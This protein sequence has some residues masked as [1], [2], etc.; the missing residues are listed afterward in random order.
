M[1]ASVK[2]RLRPGVRLVSIVLS[3]FRQAW[4]GLLRQPAFLMLAV[5]TLAL[6][7]A[8]SVTV[9]G[10]V[11]RVLLRPLPY[12]QPGQLFAM[13]LVQ[14]GGWATITPEEYQA[15]GQL[16]G[17]RD[18]GIA[19]MG[20]VPMN[21]AEASDPEMAQAIAVDVGFLETLA[22]AMALGRYF[23]AEEDVP[24]GRAAVII[25][26][27]LWL[28]RFNG[29]R[30]AV[31]RSLMLEGVPMPIVGVLP[32]SFRYT[33][34]VDLLVPLA[35]PA[36]TRDNGRNY[37]AVVRL[38]EQASAPV[39]SA[40]VDA[41]MK[42]LYA[43]TDSARF[44]QQSVFGLRALSTALSAQS[45]PVLLLF[46]A[47]ALCVLLLTAVNLANLMLMRA[48]ARSHV[49]AVRGALGAS[50]TR[51]ALPMLAEG[52]LVGLLGAMAGLGLSVLALRV[53]GERIPASWFG[54][55]AD[56]AVGAT[57]ILFAL[58][59]GVLAALSAAALG[60]WRGRTRDARRELA[61]GG[62]T[63]LSRGSGRLTRGLVVAQV[64]LATVLLVGAGVFTRALVDS[65]QVDLGY[66]TDQ[67]VGFEIAPVRALYPDAPAVR[68]MGRRVVERLQQLPGAQSA[69]LAT[70]LPIGMPLNYP[71][72]VPG[73]D[74][75]SVEFR[76][77]DDGFFASF[78]IPVVAGRGF[79]G[80]DREGGEPVLA[81]NQAFAREFLGWTGDT[82]A[83]AVLDRSVQMPVGNAL[84]T[85]RVIGVVGDTRQHGPEHA[86]PPMVYL[87]FA[88]LPDMLVQMLREFMP[89]R[90]AVQL[91]GDTYAQL[92]A[93][94]AAVGEVAPGQPLA[95]L[96]PVAELV[97]ASTDGTR[98]ALLLIGTFAGLSL[99]LSAVGLYAVVAV[100][101]GTRRREFGV[102]SALGSSRSGLFRLVLGD[103]LRQVVLGLLVGLL[104]SVAATRWLGSLLS[105]LGASDPVVWLAVSA[106]LA[107]ATM[108]ACLI[109]ALRAARVAPSAALRS[110]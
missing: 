33:A 5:T 24:N 58:L 44:Y 97:R 61:G 22:P 60:V 51:L 90:F 83:D 62:R 66:R 15:I 110:E 45:R 102:R 6:G 78:G 9:V 88:Q 104:L 69:T 38:S 4:R 98:L 80:R 35:L 91:S 50:T 67:R 79:D 92:P 34:P 42:A 13:G 94:R 74:M 18:S 109:P 99:A 89:L 40:T 107:C 10:L 75:V 86:P 103:G 70:N 93:I 52:A 27:A 101:V 1:L 49:S 105:G 37:L 68:A 100:A 8:A 64:A 28:R 26:H 65:A 87:P 29:D 43:G 73:Q 47:S 3:E 96:A 63:G 77:V 16:D 82:S 106:V 53:I 20:T 84:T 36:S 25:S 17:V 54:G 108:I 55:G 71:V 7:V 59:V 56:L 39:L 76:A 19:S 95:N 48:L 31:G 41:R 2:Q 12:Q 46:L 21:L 72:Q 57:S 14:Q 81:V 23:L 85:L 11:D 32:P 30:D